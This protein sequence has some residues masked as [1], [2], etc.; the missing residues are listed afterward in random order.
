MWKCTFI[1]C[2]NLQLDAIWMQSR[3]INNLKLQMNAQQDRYCIK[4]NEGWCHGRHHF[5][6]FYPNNTFSATSLWPYQGKPENA[7]FRYCLCSLSGSVFKYEM[8]I[9]QINWI[10]INFCCQVNYRHPELTKRQVLLKVRNFCPSFEKMSEER[11]R[12]ANFKCWIKCKAGYQKDTM[13]KIRCFSFCS[14]IFAL[15]LL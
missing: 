14:F 6:Q 3:S 5:L 11:K 1:E 10:K 2:Q 12:S 9:P 15:V 7:C 8:L 13:A 4:C